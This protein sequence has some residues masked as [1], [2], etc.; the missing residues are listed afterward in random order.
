[1]RHQRHVGRGTATSSTVAEPVPNVK[2]PPRLVSSDPSPPQRSPSPA[3]SPQR[4]ASLPPS[5]K[6]PLPLPRSRPLAVPNVDKPALQQDEHDIPDT[7]EIEPPTE[8][9]PPRSLP[10]SQIPDSIP[11]MKSR[12]KPRPVQSSSGED[13]SAVMKAKKFKTLPRASPTVFKGLHMQ[14]RR[15]QAS[16]QDPIEQF[17]SPERERKKTTRRGQ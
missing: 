15:T 10:R 2:S 8:S 16:T 4:L 1:M 17:S 3:V 11:S 9:S 7:P 12:M 6:C 5:P 13:R 14:Q